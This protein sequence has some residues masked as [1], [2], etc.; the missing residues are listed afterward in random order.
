MNHV[1]SYLPTDPV[2]HDCSI[3][4]TY[5]LDPPGEWLRSK[6][7]AATQKTEEAQQHLTQ[8]H[9]I[10]NPSG[11]NGKQYTN[12]FF[13]QQ[14]TQEQEYHCETRASCRQKQKKELGRLLSLQDKLENAWYVPYNL[15]QISVLHS[16]TSLAGP[17]TR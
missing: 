10:Q 14:W 1:V 6:L 3:L 11:I 17:Q 9:A 8:L 13:M 2:I 15:R 7:D 4:N 16:P 12:E 5:D